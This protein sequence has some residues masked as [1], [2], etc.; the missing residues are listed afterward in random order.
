M[1][2]ILV[3]ALLTAPAAVAS[4]IGSSL[5]TVMLAAGVITLLSCLGG[6]WL[7]YSLQIPSGAAIALFAAAIYAGAHIIKRLRSQYG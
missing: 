2:I 3:M 5:K 6:L 7:S 1:G 4:L